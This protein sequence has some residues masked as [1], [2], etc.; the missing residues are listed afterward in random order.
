MKELLTKI[1]GKAGR[2]G[3]VLA[4]LAGTTVA[5]I[6]MAP[7]ASAASCYG[8]YCSGQDPAATG[9]A[10]DG[11]TVAAT[12]VYVNNWLGQRVYGGFLELRWSPNCKT[13]WARFSPQQ[14]FSYNLTA[15]QPQTGYRQDYSK[16]AWATAWTSQIYSPT[17]CVYAE[18]HSTG[19]Y[20]TGTTRT[21]CI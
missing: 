10:A 7:T 20:F 9:C 12:D 13:N 19:F 2:V 15:Y 21:A 18:M 11:V 17:K 8:D 5:G 14:G 1:R 6:A 4:L 3:A 16:P